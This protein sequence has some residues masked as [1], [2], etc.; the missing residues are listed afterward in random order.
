MRD[1]SGLSSYPGAMA[2][3]RISNVRAAA[4]FGLLG[5]VLALGFTLFWPITAV[6]T[7][8]LN[9]VI[10]Y[11]IAFAINFV[12]RTIKYRDRAKPAADVAGG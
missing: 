1:P 2:K 3:K 6:P 12:F 9:S 10:G 5:V 4:K 8:I 11:A 7:L